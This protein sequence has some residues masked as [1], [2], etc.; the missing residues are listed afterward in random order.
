M[1]NV[2]LFNEYYMFGPF[3]TFAEI[4]NVCGNVSNDFDEK[5]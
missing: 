4:G 2:V 3:Q 5:K 1:Q